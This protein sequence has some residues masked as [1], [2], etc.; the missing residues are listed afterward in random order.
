MFKF[1]VSGAVIL[2]IMEIAKGSVPDLSWVFAVCSVVQCSAVQ[3]SAVQCSAV[4]CSA[5]QC[6]AVQCSAVQCS[7]V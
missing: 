4:Q 6:S 2:F 3:C 1:R 7:A 5:V